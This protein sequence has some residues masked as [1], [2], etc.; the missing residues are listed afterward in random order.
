M[1]IDRFDCAA[2][3]SG[4]IKFDDLG[5]GKYPV[6]RFSI[7]KKSSFGGSRLLVHIG[8]G[9]VIMPARIS[10]EF[11]TPTEVRKLNEGKHIF[12]YMGKD[13]SRMNRLDFRL[14]PCVNVPEKRNAKQ[15]RN[16]SNNDQSFQTINDKIDQNAVEQSAKIGNKTVTTKKRSATTTDNH[17]D[18]LPSKKV[19]IT[20]V[21]NPIVATIEQNAATIDNHTDELSIEQTKLPGMVT[22]IIATTEQNAATID[23]HTE[24]LPSEEV[25][26]VG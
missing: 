13:A 3:T 21:D 8:D 4:Y 15:S 19:K 10:D 14:E 24:E 23:N 6:K 20:V 25:E 26:T 11:A 7:M 1:S 2:R 5:V 22:P 16:E 9:Y 17:I 12:S 18:G